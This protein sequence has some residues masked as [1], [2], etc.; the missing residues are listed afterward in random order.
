MNTKP[1]TI[2][3]IKS[4]EAYAGLTDEQATEVLH[5]IET[6]S[7]ILFENMKNGINFDIS[8]NINTINLDN[9][10]KNAA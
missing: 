1:I 3:Q 4:I 2:E 5:T 6:I 10:Y 8:L 7:Y 9:Q